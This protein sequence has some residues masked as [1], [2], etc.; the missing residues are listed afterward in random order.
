MYTGLKWNIAKNL[1]VCVEGVRACAC[2]HVGVDQGVAQE[3][4]SNKSKKKIKQKKNPKK[5]EKKIQKNL[6][7]CVEGV[8]MCACT[9]V[10]D[11]E[12]VAHGLK[13]NK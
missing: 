11:E 5:F 10:G 13:P 6:S 9:H 3:L 1:S 7:V 8:R 4:K 12:G 2:T